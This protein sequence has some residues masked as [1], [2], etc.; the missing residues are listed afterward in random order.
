MGT[1]FDPAKEAHVMTTATWIV[2]NTRPGPGV[3]KYKGLAGRQ[4]LTGHEMEILAFV[5]LVGGVTCGREQ[6][7]WGNVMGGS[8]AER[9]ESIEIGC[10]KE[11][12]GKVTPD[13]QAIV[14]EGNAMRQ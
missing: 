13:P 9:L 12:R 14:A 5:G 11:S 10:P 1:D 7:F 2:C 6:S 3:R 4:E 8:D